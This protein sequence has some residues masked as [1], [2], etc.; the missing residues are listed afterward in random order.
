MK[1]SEPQNGP[2]ANRGYGV[3][4]ANIILASLG[5]LAVVLRHFVTR[6][7]KVALDADDILIIVALVSNGLMISTSPIADLGSKFSLLLCINTCVA[8]PFL[9]LGYSPATM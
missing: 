3:L 7:K 5:T 9:G 8:M 1:S 2:H 4:I 6:A